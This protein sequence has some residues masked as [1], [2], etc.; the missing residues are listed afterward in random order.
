MVAKILSSG[1][2]FSSVEYNSNKVDKG[3]GELMLVKNLSQMGNINNIS[4]ESIKNYLKAVSNTNK[5]VKKPQFHCAISCKGKEFDKKELTVIAEKYMDKMGY[6]KQP[7]LVIFHNDTANNH[8]HIVSTRIG[9]DGKK[10]NDSNERYRSKTAIKEILEKDYNIKKDNNLK[11]LFDYKYSTINQLKLLLVKSGYTLSDENNLLKIYK[12]GDLQKEIEHSKIELADNFSEKRNEQIRA[13]IFKYSKEY[14]NNVF[15]VYEKL[16]G[17]REGKIIGYESDL[18][19]YLKS[20]FG[21]Q[22]VFH[23]SGGKIPFGFSLIDNK[24]KSVLKGSDIFKIK[25]LIGEEIINKT[26]EKNYNKFNEVN[27]YNINSF[28]NLKVLS[29]LYQ[30]PPDKIFPNERALSKNETSYYKSL[31]DVFFKNNNWLDMSKINI[32]PVVESGNLYLVDKLGLNVV[33]ASE[34]LEQRKIDEFFENRKM[35]FSNEEEIKDSIDFGWSLANDVDDEKVH[36]KERN[37]KGNKR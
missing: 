11:E 34:V 36:G 32:Y 28:A 15:P 1:G 20:S 19:N 4:S 6:S 27:S 24:N 31:L 3:K 26:K 23:F 13:L 12:N 33:P 14:S 35:N 7:Y 8:I 30:I 2:S 37:K 17:D 25:A 29:N 16:K 18:T 9:K 21:L 10:I 22:F 5:R